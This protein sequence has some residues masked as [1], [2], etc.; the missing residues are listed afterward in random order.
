MPTIMETTEIYGFI[1][2]ISRKYYYNESSLITTEKVNK[3]ALTAENV[4]DYILSFAN[5]AQDP[6]TNLKLQ[7]LLYYSQGYYLALNDCVLFEDEIEAWAHGPVIPDIY[8]NFKR[9]R[10]H[11]IDEEV[12]KPTLTEHFVNYL[13]ILIETFLPIEAYKLEQMTH[14]EAP[15]INARDGLPPDALCRVIIKIDDMRD[16]FKKLIADE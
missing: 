12:E 14:N 7:K 13:E 5:E 15:W 2:V 16:Y 4:A 11:P 10:W 6:I 3:M 8:H 9:F 1:V